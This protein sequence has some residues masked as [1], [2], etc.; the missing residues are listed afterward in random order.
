MI[1]TSTKYKQQ[2]IAGNRRYVTKVNLTLADNT[3]LLLTNEELWEQGVVISNGISDE[4][5]FEIC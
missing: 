5:S 1:S 3:T 2:L 4:S